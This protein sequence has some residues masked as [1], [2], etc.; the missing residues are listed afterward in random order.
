M[1]E[2]WYFILPL[3]FLIAGC[4][5]EPI[6]DPGDLADIPYK[7]TPYVVPVPP[8]FP[9]MEIPPDNPLTVEG[10]WLGRKLFYDPI[11]S[12]DS[13]MS[14]ASCHAQDMNFTDNLPVSPGITGA[15]GRRSSMSLLNVAFHYDG[16]FWDGRSPTLEEQAL[17]PVEDPVELHESW[18][19]VEAKLRRHTVYP[20]DF[21]KA[22]G[23]THSSQITRDLAVKAIAQFERTM[24]S[25][26]MSKYDRFVRGEV[27]LTDSEY[28]GYDMFFDL[29]SDFPDA[30]CAHCHAP[31]LFTTNE[32]RNNGIEPIG[33]IF[34]FGDKGR[35][36][37]TGDPA[38]FGKF[39]TPT[40]RNIE[41][42]A[43]YMHDGRF[44]TLMEVLD[45]YNSGGHRQ[46]NTDGFIYRLRLTQQE[47]LDIISFLMTLS[48]PDFLTNPD[49][50]N[51]F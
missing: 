11:L 20:S 37:V 45:H 13:T 28:N 23:I 21:R 15:L 29:S 35:G 9:A 50:S 2:R 8:G 26:G 39:K 33:S 46:E 47:K 41:F 40:L 5:K 14:C 17:L 34:D 22:F 25:S 48:D 42:T 49:F 4:G 18:P 43:P 6:V 30:E 3:L 1:V 7:P 24:V 19:N 32:F 44:T 38:D 51:P 12:A 10:I 27:F 31:P 36:E 16:F